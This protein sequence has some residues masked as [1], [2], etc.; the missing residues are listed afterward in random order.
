MVE[1]FSVAELSALRS[2]LLKGSLDSFQV[3]ELFNMFLRGRGYGVSSAEALGAVVSVEGK[4]CTLEAL[5]TEL[6]RLA[7]V[8]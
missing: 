4:G 8:Q 2:E 5:Q 6:E 7:Y 1:K 3:A